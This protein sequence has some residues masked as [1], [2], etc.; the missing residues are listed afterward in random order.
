MNLWVIKGNGSSGRLQ[1]AE[2]VLV[3]RLH[4]DY[5]YLMR[6][7]WGKLDLCNPLSQM[8]WEQTFRFTESPQGQLEA[9]G[10]E[11]IVERNPETYFQQ[12]KG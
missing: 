7:M 12:R 9:R 3:T 11:V 5:V 8:K 2:D 1:G 6:Q 4:F 10:Q